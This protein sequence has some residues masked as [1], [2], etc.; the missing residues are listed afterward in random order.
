MGYDYP[1]PAE[2]SHDHIY[3]P[4]VLM[5]FKRKIGMIEEVVKII[6]AKRIIWGSDLSLLDLWY[7]IKRYIGLKQAMIAVIVRKLDKFFVL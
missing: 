2:G 7:E 3:Q 1:K 4:I 5:L 6:G